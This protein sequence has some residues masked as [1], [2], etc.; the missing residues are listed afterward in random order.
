MHYQIQSHN[1]L[2]NEHR[3]RARERELQEVPET[4]QTGATAEY[5]E[6]LKSVHLGPTQ[7]QHC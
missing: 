7:Y 1:S 6:Q 2:N 3:N 4:E 5:T